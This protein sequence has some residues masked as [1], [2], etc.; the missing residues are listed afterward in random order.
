[1]G[2]VHGQINAVNSYSLYIYQNTKESSEGSA[3]SAVTFK[4]M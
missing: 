1:M 2:K 4:E 3:D